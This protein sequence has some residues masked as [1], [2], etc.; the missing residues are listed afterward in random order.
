[1]SIRSPDNMDIKIDLKKKSPEEYESKLREIK[2]ILLEDKVNL[3]GLE[4]FVQVFD[5]LLNMDY[6]KICEYL[7][8]GKCDLTKGLFYAV[9]TGLMD[10]E[11]LMM[12]D[13]NFLNF[14][15]IFERIEK[16][17]GAGLVI[18]SFLLMIV[19]HRF[20]DD[21]HVQDLLRLV[22]KIVQGKDNL[23]E[24]L[25]L[26]IIF[27]RVVVKGK[28]INDEV[29][30]RIWNLVYLKMGYNE[31]CEQVVFK[32]KQNFNS[33]SDFSSLY[34][35]FHLCTQ[36]YTELIF[37]LVNF[38]ILDFLILSIEQRQN[39]ESSE[40]ILCCIIEILKNSQIINKRVKLVT[41][42]LKSS[43]KQSAMFRVQSFKYLQIGLSSAQDDQIDEFFSNLIK[44]SDIKIV[45]DILK[46]FGSPLAPYVQKRLLEKS[47]ISSL[48]TI[49]FKSNKQLPE[50][51]PDLFSELWVKILYFLH[52]FDK[53]SSIIIKSTHFEKLIMKLR[54]DSFKPFQNYVIFES[55]NYIQK[56]YETNSDFFYVILEYISYSHFSTRYP[57][58]KFQYLKNFKLNKHKFRKISK[59][60]E[61][62]FFHLT[63]ISEDFWKFYSKILTKCFSIKISCKIIKRFSEII[64]RSK[65]RY[66]KRL[67]ICLKNSLNTIQPRDNL[68]REFD[69]FDETSQFLINQKEEIFYCKGKISIA[70]R[71]RLAKRC[72]DC[73]LVDLHDLNGFRMRLGLEDKRIKAQAFGSKGSFEIQSNEKVPI[74]IWVF[75]CVCW[76]FK[77]KPN[78]F[79]MVNEGN[80]S[81]GFKGKINKG[82]NCVS[83]SLGSCLDKSLRF[84]GKISSIQIYKKFLSEPEIVELRQFTKI[85]PMNISTNRE[86]QLICKLKSDL[87]FFYGGERKSPLIQNKSNIKFQSMTT[88]CKGNSIYNAL[89]CISGLEGLRSY[90]LED[91]IVFIEIL[92]ILFRLSEVSEIIP[93]NFP[94]LITSK[95]ASFSSS[96][97]LK[98]TYLRFIL[99]IYSDTLL[100][101]FLFYYL[102]EPG[103]YCFQS[104]NSLEEADKMVIIFKRLFEKDSKYFLLLASAFHGMDAI[105]IKYV[106][107]HFMED[108]SN[109]N[110]I[111][112]ILKILIKAEEFVFIESIVSLVE[113][114]HF[115]GV[116]EDFLMVFLMML[117]HP[118]SIPF[119]ASL[120]KIVYKEIN[121]TF[122][123]DM[124]KGNKR[125]INAIGFIR[126]R[127]TGIDALIECLSHFG[128]KS[129]IFDSELKQ[130]FL[131]VVLSKTRYS[132]SSCSYGKLL[133]FFT[134][135]K[136]ICFNMIYS[137][138]IFPSWII[139]FASKQ[140]SYALGI[141]EIIYSNVEAIDDISKIYVFFK[142]ISKDDKVLMLYKKISE[143]FLNKGLFKKPESFAD[144]FMILDLF[145]V[146]C[147]NCQIITQILEFT[148]DF[149]LGGFIY[150]VQ[151]IGNE[152]SPKSCRY[153]IFTFLKISI[154][155]LK[156]SSNP[157][158]LEKILD[159]A[160]FFKSLKITSIETC[161]DL[162]LFTETCEIL[163]SNTQNIQTF[164]EH[165][166]NNSDIKPKIIQFFSNTQDFIPDQIRF[167]S[168]KS[169]SKSLLNSLD[170][171][172]LTLASQETLIKESQGH[173][174]MGLIQLQDWIIQIHFHLLY[175]LVLP[176]KK[177]RYK[178]SFTCYKENELE[179]NS[180][181]SNRFQEILDNVDIEDFNTEQKLRRSHLKTIEHSYKKELNKKI[182]LIE[183]ILEGKFFIKNR[184]DQ[185]YRW[186]F[187]KFTE[188]KLNIDENASYLCRQ[189]RISTIDLSI[190]ESRINNSTIYHLPSKSTMTMANPNFAQMECEQIKI[191]GS[192]FGLVSFTDKF[193]EIKLRPSK[194]SQGDYPQS[195][196]A[197]TIK[198]KRS[199]YVFHKDDI[200]EVL[201]RRF[202]HKNSAIEV[203]MKKG[204]SFFINLFKK[205][206]RE[207]AFKVMSKWEDVKVI[208][209][210]SDIPLLQIKEKWSNGQISTM[211][212]LLLLNKY[213]GRSFHDI[214]QYPVFPW[215]LNKFDGNELDIDDP[216][217]YR[218][219][220]YPIGAQSVKRRQE[221]MNNYRFSTDIREKY[222]FG[223][224]YSNGAIVLYYLIRMEP[225]TTQH[226]VLQDGHFDHADRLFFSLQCAWDSSQL[227][228][229]DCKEM[230]PEMYY[231]PH[232]YENL[233][234]FSF[235]VNTF[236]K[237]DSSEFQLPPWAC[238]S[239]DLVRKLRK[240]LESSYTSSNIHNW[241]DL[242]FGCKQS[243]EQAETFC[244]LFHPITY[245]EFYKSSIKYVEPEFMKCIV[246]QIYHFGQ[247]PSKLFKEP[248]TKRKYVP[249]LSIFELWKYSEGKIAKSI[250]LSKQGDILDLMCDSHFLFIFVVYPDCIKY[251][252]FE[253]TGKRPS[254][255]KEFQ[256]KSMKISDFFKISVCLWNT[257]IV[258]AGFKDFSIK[259]FDYEGEQKFIIA[260]HP[261]PVVCL[262]SAEKLFSGSDVLIAW[263]LKMAKYMMFAG[264]K[265]K[266]FSV[267]C[268][269]TNNIVTSC[270]SL[271]NILVHDSRSSELLFSMNTSPGI[272]IVSSLNF[273]LVMCQS[274]MKAFS[275][276]GR[277]I[278]ECDFRCEMNVAI[279]KFGD[280]LIG[281]MNNCI[282]CC[283]ILE[284]KVYQ[285][286]NLGYLGFC[287]SDDEKSIFGLSSS[288]ESF[289]LDIFSVNPKKFNNKHS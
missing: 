204:K 75:V 70:L 111:T 40:D 1:M 159:K 145:K 271:G 200:S 130:I 5:E 113:C 23:G 112:S 162:Y 239:W 81:L 3:Q 106:L 226:K 169:N 137:K 265:S 156:F 50:A 284:K 124:K 273:F 207:K 232:L 88:K 61:I 233:N 267:F 172:S 228:I 63:E 65:S 46:S 214:S 90:N 255:M 26:P 281:I 170:F 174:I 62:I 132:M 140:L 110:S 51:N 243:G 268:N 195:A 171:N 64:T 102:N 92:S 260:F 234:N 42:I 246:D 164:L 206:R 199:H 17:D 163:Y 15:Q 205:S 36:D 184:M 182:D 249:T 73:V 220:L 86:S 241:I 158:P 141:A 117:S 54:K 252:R 155:S 146:T 11:S 190:I 250:N 283:D 193:F 125:S 68:I 116:C 25:I 108:F 181:L 177:L 12:V 161:L 165:L 221:L 229:G 7:V 10:N 105:N 238:S 230:I 225:F 168:I 99:Q 203:F 197:F 274:S 84:I 202:I 66:I 133:I 128:V 77:D 173:N 76:E 258:A 248:H 222:H 35:F 263:N 282:S 47:L 94:E 121:T 59:I 101:K 256:L 104:V 143:I 266:I 264:H 147:L 247:T 208:K 160:H 120:V 60:Q 127:F 32:I 149:L 24:N 167:S 129:G 45:L 30:K 72:G 6:F 213:S 91:F 276:D 44:E 115:E 150:Y 78:A 157:S 83:L 107:R 34:E 14:L 215:V 153:F 270:D 43:L 119:Q 261:T 211:E 285:A 242:I 254:K 275:F 74:G 122:R 212:Y 58:L 251:L 189:S 257:M 96:Q 185:L 103:L 288:K 210:I 217:F 52:L 138:N 95:A 9:Q 175:K 209:S 280:Y 286:D 57:V 186:A 93:Q 152:L 22:L 198:C 69:Y 100:K 123:H 136:D 231:L 56:F 80:W 118:L 53:S 142:Q 287:I 20:F 48:Y 201:F 55:F 67:L 154:K 41:I 244:N 135:N 29:W 178:P 278:S 134:E 31:I 180:V 18:N 2:S 13:K 216:S 192:Y 279:C 194:K 191:D 79:L 187:V 277:L 176:L 8:L 144:F 151:A 28:F 39:Q 49:L 223:Q 37:E 139:E 126:E 219:F 235:G 148:I 183:S 97:E 253:L 224:H 227:C 188:R 259:F 131:D 262:F 85:N 218:D 38:N 98:Q 269:D 236:L 4:G 109:R 21:R 19:E 179:E 289:R 240:S 27:C 245:Q 71:L 89:K 114:C 16:C 87:V 196:L 33:S 272:T 82:M 237:K 166:I